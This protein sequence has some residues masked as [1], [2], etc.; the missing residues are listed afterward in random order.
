M[1]QLV[2]HIVH[3][4]GVTGSSPVA[5]TREALESQGSRAFLSLAG[6][7]M[8]SHGPIH[9]PGQDGRQARRA[10]DAQSRRPDLSPCAKK[11]GK[12]KAPRPQEKRPCRNPFSDMGA[13]LLS[14]FLLSH[15]AVYRFPLCLRLPIASS[16]RPQRLASRSA[17]HRPTRLWSPVCGGSTVS[18]QAAYTVVL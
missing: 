17:S 6:E 3:I 5:T 2:E 12:Q 4:D 9:P 16:D 7:R 14:S 18:V 8:F 13:F 15:R 1:A 11:S 10:L